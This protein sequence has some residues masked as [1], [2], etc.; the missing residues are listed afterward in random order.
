MTNRSCWSWP[1]AWRKKRKDGRLP[2]RA[3]LGWRVRSNN[4][5]MHNRKRLV[6]GTER[7]TLIIHSWG[8]ARFGF[9]TGDWAEVAS[10]AA[11]ILPPVEISDGCTDP[12]VGTSV[13]NGP[14]VN[15]KVRRNGRQRKL[16]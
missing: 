1:I 12:L 6:K 5:W 13:L 14:V 16:A 11:R 4:S 3:E 8:A 7:C 10:S 9:Q 2:V 15:V